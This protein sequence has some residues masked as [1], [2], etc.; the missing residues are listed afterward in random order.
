MISL[1]SEALWLT[2]QKHLRDVALESE[3]ET[4]VVEL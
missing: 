2:M 3:D 1:W 4:E